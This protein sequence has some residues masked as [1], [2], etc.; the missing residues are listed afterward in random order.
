MTVAFLHT[1]ADCF[2]HNMFRRCSKG[3][4][5]YVKARMLIVQICI[6]PIRAYMFGLA[7][8]CHSLRLYSYSSRYSKP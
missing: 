6:A 8:I 3:H 5:S 7:G 2:W 1:T 4:C